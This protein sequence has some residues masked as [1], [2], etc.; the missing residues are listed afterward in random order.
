MAAFLLLTKPALESFE[1]AIL[2]L[3]L[4]FDWLDAIDGSSMPNLPVIFGRFPLLISKLEL[5]FDN[6]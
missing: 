4:L 6:V 5:C 3:C 2:L 1:P